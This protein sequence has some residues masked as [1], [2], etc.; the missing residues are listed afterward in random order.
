MRTYK[1]LTRYQRYHIRIYLKVGYSQSK[2]A[3]LI[4]VHKSTVSREIRRNKDG[5]KYNP[6]KAHLKALRRRRVAKKYIKMQ[7]ELIYRVEQLLRLDFSPEQISG[8][9]A[10]NENIRI[11]HETIY[12][13]IWSDKKK[14]GQLY[15]HL[16]CGRRKYRKRYGS[17]Q[18][19]G[20]IVGA[21]SID[22]RPKIVD[23]KSRIGDWE[24]DTMTG[25]QRKGALLTIVERRSKF[26][27]IKKLPDRN[28]KRLSSAVA[29]L[30]RPYKDK[31]LT[32]TV[33]NGKEFAQHTRIS[34]LL[35]ADVYFAHPYHAWER[36]LNENTNGLLR[37][38][39]PKGTDFTKIKKDL[40]KLAMDRL[41][42][43]PRKTLN[44]KS[45]ND[46]F[47]GNK[48][49]QQFIANCCTY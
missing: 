26:T 28:A 5:P 24:I 19:R 20:R 35:E 41:N 38:Y 46:V 1:Q 18:R 3:E 14:G 8:Y 33:D 39:F 47:L 11:S 44:F 25:K 32:I 48:N 45:P 4:E 34:R 17:K 43:R 6:K 27:L 13:Y 7:P 12:R 16:R 37:Q 42:L 30:M 29:H 2:I 21:V 36:G 40:V 10:H 23:A 49:N 31:V 9:L 15:R 22:K